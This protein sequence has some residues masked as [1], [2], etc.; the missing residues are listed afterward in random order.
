MGFKNI[1]AQEVVVDK[2]VPL[3]VNQLVGLPGV[4]PTLHVV[5]LGE[6]NTAFW[7]DALARAGTSTATTRRGKPTAAMIRANRADNRKTVA[8]YAVRGIEGFYHDGADGRPDAARPATLADVDE[9][10]DSLPDEVFDTVLAFV[11]NP[12]NFRERPVEGDVKELS[13]KS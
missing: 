13:G 12:E 5:H 9:L 11:S 7:N 6:S 2:T 8:K 4:D 3:V 1:R 10:I